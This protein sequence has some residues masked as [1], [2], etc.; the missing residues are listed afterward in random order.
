M[1]FPAAHGSLTWGIATLLDQKVTHWKW[2]L[3]WFLL[4]IT[5]DFDFFPVLFLDLSRR[6]FHRTFTHS[7]VFVLLTS[8]AVFLVGRRAGLFQGA[9]GWLAI[10][11]VLASH[12]ALDFFCISDL[13]RDGEML[14]WPFSRAT[15]G[16]VS[17]LV[18]LYQW[19]AGGPGT[20]LEVAVPYTVLEVL[21]W[22]PLTLWVVWKNRRRQRKAECAPPAT[23]QNELS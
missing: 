7:V 12:V 13:N 17:I 8:V 2:A 19:V 22:S 5:P 6:Q 15:Y 14:L 1:A 11:L 4:S 18:P 16:Q 3:F 10:C 23:L 20:L 21:L 9:K